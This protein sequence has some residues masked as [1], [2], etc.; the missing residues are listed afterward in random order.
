MKLSLSY[1]LKN[2][3]I[4][5]LLFAAT[6]LMNSCTKDEPL[7]NISAVITSTFTDSKEA[8]AKV[9]FT[10][11]GVGEIEKYEW[12]FGDGGTGQGKTGS[13][14]YKQASKYTVILTITGD[15][16][17]KKSRQTVSKKITHEVTVEEPQPSITISTNF[18][19]N[20]QLIP[21]TVTFTATNSRPVRILS[22]EWT[23]SDGRKSNEEN[24]S[25]TFDKGGEY[26]I[27]LKVT[28]SRGTFTFTA[29]AFG[30]N[31]LP[32]V[33][34]KD[35]TDITINSA[36]LWASLTEA[37]F[38]IPTAIKAGFYL[39]DGTTTRYISVNN[40]LG[41][42]N[43][44]KDF[45]A[46]LDG[47][48]ADRAY[49][50]YAAIE[51][52]NR[53]E[54]KGETKTFRTVK[55]VLP[56]INT[57]AVTEIAI[58]S[59]RL[60]LTITDRGIPAAISRYGFVWSASST[61]PTLANATAIDL[62]S[63]TSSV[64]QNLSQN[65]TYYVRAFAINMAGTAYGN[66]VTF[67]TRTP[68]PKLPTVLTLAV[69]NIAD[70]TAKLNLN[71]TDVGFPSPVT[72]TGWIFSTTNSNLTIDSGNGRY[73]WENNYTSPTALSSDMKDLQSGTTYY[74]RSYATNATGTSYGETVSFKTTG[75]SPKAIPDYT[76]EGTICAK[77]GQFD[78]GG[79]NNLKAEGSMTK[80]DFT[81]RGGRC[82]IKSMKVRW[83]FS[84]FFGDAF[85]SGGMVWTAETG[86]SVDC[87]NGS[88][89]IIYLKLQDVNGNIVYLNRNREFIFPKSGQSAITSAN[90]PYWKDTFCSTEKSIL[91]TCLTAQQ[92][93]DFWIRGFKVIDFVVYW[94][95]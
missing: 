93:K 74:I 19:N 28:T 20:N 53:Q 71:L 63:S 92:A 25:F 8:P 58:S 89:T 50:Y 82:V 15:E 88:N 80:C 38:P 42:D 57:D 78:V 36:K 85:L 37:G 69:T 33:L 61:V 30:V 95:E 64:L 11:D 65:T 34:T 73:W 40:A 47:L 75:L 60:N 67:R 10:A 24:P 26:S 43:L 2:Y 70:K 23:L 22:W 46:T 76:A 84:T 41:T 59:G 55:P 17:S 79:K 90:L 35:A 18:L 86:T 77:E 31:A 16:G 81:V 1:K 91:N 72:E 52:A 4:A 51:L 3:A 29:N 62:T 39:I 68:D 54:I 32:K 83:G 9:S 45:S 44:P 56:T 27:T 49:S 94:S 13:Y 66:V 21:T 6:L 87:I 48:A 12:N 14:T 5:S 7:P